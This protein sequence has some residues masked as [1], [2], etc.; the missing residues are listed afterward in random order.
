MKQKHR[1][2]VYVF[3]CLT[4]SCCE[5]IVSCQCVDVL[6]TVLC[7]LFVQDLT[8]WQ[9]CREL[10]VF[11]FFF[12]KY[13]GVKYLSG[14]HISQKLAILCCNAKLWPQKQVQFDIVLSECILFPY[15]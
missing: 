7:C 1:M 10:S 5:I 13:S 14:L 2:S 11:F 8:G 15:Q 9:H 6:A 3:G 4:A 12:G